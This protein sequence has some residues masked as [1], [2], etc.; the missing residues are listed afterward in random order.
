[1]FAMRVS[2]VVALVGLSLVFVGCPPFCGSSTL[3][4]CGSDGDCV[5]GGCS[6]QLCG[7]VDEDLTSTCEWRECYDNEP[8]GLECGCVQ[9]ECDWRRGP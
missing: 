5:A 4:P 9:G 7:G 1:M 8:Y 6:G 3:A 2:M